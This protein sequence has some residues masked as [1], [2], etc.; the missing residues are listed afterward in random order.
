MPDNS[1]RMGGTMQLPKWVETMMEEIS[2]AT[3]CGVMVAPAR[4]T[5]LFRRLAD[6][7]GLSMH[8]MFSALIENV[9]AAVERGDEGVYISFHPEPA[10]PPCDR[11][12]QELQIYNA[13]EGT[14]SYFCPA[15]DTAW[16]E[17]DAA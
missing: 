14:W 3:G 8:D 9:M 2:E 16:E 17:N 10:V 13:D 11:C 15:C 4:E 6:A 5:A 7:R 12:G 1:P